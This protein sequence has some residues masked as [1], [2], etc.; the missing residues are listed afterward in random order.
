MKSLIKRIFKRNNGTVAREYKGFSDF[1]LRAS[2]EEKNMVFT[3]AARKA[4]EDQQ[5]T[6]R[7]AKLK[8][9]AN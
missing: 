5:R 9:G 6:F 4:N 1:F 3:E 2:D 8:V 7:E